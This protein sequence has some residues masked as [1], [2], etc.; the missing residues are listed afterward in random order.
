[1]IAVGVLLPLSLACLG[2]LPRPGQPVLVFA[3]PSAGPSASARLVAAAGGTVLAPGPLADA[4]LA[5]SDAPDFAARLYA[6]GA[7]LVVDAALAGPCT[8]TPRS[9]PS[10]GSS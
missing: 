3:A 1:M 6:A 8:A 2:L 5:R 7:L 10:L 9:D 4:A